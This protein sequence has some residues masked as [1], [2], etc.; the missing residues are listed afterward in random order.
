MAN[1]DYIAAEAVK[2]SSLI[3]ALLED[4]L[5]DRFDQ[6]YGKARA[7]QEERRQQDNRVLEHPRNWS[8]AYRKEMCVKIQKW[9]GFDC[10]KFYWW[11]V[12]SFFSK[13]EVIKHNLYNPIQEYVSPKTGK[14]RT[15]RKSRVHQHLDEKTTVK[16]LEFNEYL[17]RLVEVCESRT[18][19]ENKWNKK[20]GQPTQL[21]IFD[22]WEFAS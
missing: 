3:D 12:Y 15:A 17:W 10:S 6:A 11:Y 18:E 1:K 8:A 21:E 14:K 16:L 7:T 9:F 4:S 13:S 20:Y 22:L 2:A 5:R 19:F